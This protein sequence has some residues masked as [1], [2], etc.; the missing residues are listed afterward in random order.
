MEITGWASTESVSGLE[1]LAVALAGI[2]GGIHLVLG[3]AFLPDPIAVAFVLAGLGFAGALALFLL[4]IRRRLLYA[5]GVPFVAA[6][7]AAWLAI[8]RPA[9]V[10]D[11]GPLEAVD[12]VVQVTLIV[13]LL[14]LLARD[15]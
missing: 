2:T 4:E 14:G 13:V 15:S 1:W 6:Q 5:L 10:G 12:K 9:G 11:V 7:I 3:F 8:A